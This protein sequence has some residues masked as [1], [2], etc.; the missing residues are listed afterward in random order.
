[1]IG[2]TIGIASITVR[3]I[4]SNTSDCYVQEPIPGV[5]GYNE[6]DSNAD[7]VHVVSDRTLLFLDTH[8][9]LLRSI[10]MMRVCLQREYR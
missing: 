10:H 9:E 7:T 2:P 3:R 4:A 5:G 1:M 6:M 8:S